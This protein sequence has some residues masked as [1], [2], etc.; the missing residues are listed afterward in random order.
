[1]EQHSVTKRL[2]ACEWCDGDLTGIH[3]PLGTDT[4]EPGLDTTAAQYPQQRLP[5]L[6][7]SRNPAVVKPLREDML[8]QRFARWIRADEDAR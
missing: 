7:Y 3:G 1:L 8:S 2:F 6:D 4:T 5:F